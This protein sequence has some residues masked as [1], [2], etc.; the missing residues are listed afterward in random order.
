MVLLD[1][2]CYCYGI[3]VVVEFD[4]IDVGGFTVAAAICV[5]VD[6]VTQSSRQIL[7]KKP[8]EKKVISF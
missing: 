1:C 6:V 8:K 5:A 7:L 4:L 3:D 2:C